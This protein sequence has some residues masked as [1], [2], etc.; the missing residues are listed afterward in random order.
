MDAHRL[1]TAAVH[2]GIIVVASSVW[3][4]LVLFCLLLILQSGGG[5]AVLGLAIMIWLV[6]TRF[7][8]VV[9]DSDGQR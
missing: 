1:L 5:W 4:A 7:L 9:K 2:A 3:L 8:Y 6:L